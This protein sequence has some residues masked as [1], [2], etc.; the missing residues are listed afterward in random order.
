[1]PVAHIIPISVLD[2]IT[3]RGGIYVYYILFHLDH[4]LIASPQIAC[5]SRDF[6]CGIDTNNFGL[7]FQSFSCL[8]DQ[9]L[10]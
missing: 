1:M 2:S 6:N 3:I 4:H 7:N 9:F 8:N 5:L 10:L